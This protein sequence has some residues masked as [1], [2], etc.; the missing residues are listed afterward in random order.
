M[1]SNQP[2]RHRRSDRHTEKP[3]RGKTSGGFWIGVFSTAIA[4]ITINQIPEFLSMVQDE[5]CKLLKIEKYMT[6][7]RAL[8]AFVVTFVFFML[9]NA[10]AFWVLQ[11]IKLLFKKKKKKKK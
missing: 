6:N 9:I 4:A 7:N 11:F 3:K 1:V 10:I 5:V 2:A 8:V